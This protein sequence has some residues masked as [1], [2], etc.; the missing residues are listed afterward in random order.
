ML[1]GY[2]SFIIYIK[3]EDFYGD[4]SDNV[5]EWFDTSNYNHDVDRPL[6]E[7]MKKKKNFFC[8]DELGGNIMKEFAGLSAK[9]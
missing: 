6:P 2:S 5:G 7:G 9:T 1:H 8:K 4:I 3:T